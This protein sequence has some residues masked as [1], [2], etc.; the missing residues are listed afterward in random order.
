[1]NIEIRQDKTSGD[2]VIIAPGRG[3]R[4]SDFVKKPEGA[5]SREPEYDPDC[6]FC[7]GNEDKIPP[8]LEELPGPSGAIWQTRVIPNKY[9]IVIPEAEEPESGDEFYRARPATGIHE[10]I[11][12]SPRHNL[13]LSQMPAAAVEMVLKTYR[14]R[15]LNITESDPEFSIVIFRNRGESAGT[16]LIHPHS[17]L[18]A[19]RII[20]PRLE[21][22][23]EVARDYFRRQGNC[24]YCDIL[25]CEDELGKRVV[26]R[27]NSFIAFI[28]FAARVPFEIWIAPRSHQPV[29]GSITDE[30]IRELAEILIRI[31]RLLEKPLGKFDYNYVLSELPPSPE[32]EACSHWHLKIYPRLTQ[33]AGFEIETGI[34][35]NPTLPEKNVEELI[36]KAA[37]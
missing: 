27:T 24:L 36:K 13:D 16:S 1:M 11:I 21:R 9:P 17:Q 2:W 31:L 35:V 12:E 4:P 26:A 15:Y 22:R 14:N 19:S 30:E 18:I 29:F 8:I 20:S 7:P 3:K 37:G 28:P 34:G 23:T 33:A 10:I 6:P 5:K 32:R 25:R